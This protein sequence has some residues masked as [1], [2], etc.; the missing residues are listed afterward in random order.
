VFYVTACSCEAA[1]KNVDPSAVNPVCDADGDCICQDASKIYVPGSG[2]IVG[3]EWQSFFFKELY[4]VINNY[5]YNNY[6]NK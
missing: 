1:N 3:S 4:W 6:T 5:I 2:C